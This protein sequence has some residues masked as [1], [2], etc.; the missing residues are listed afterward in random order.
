V[1][2]GHD[3]DSQRFEP[4]GGITELVAGAGGHGRYPVH[5][6]YPRLAF[7]DAAHYAALRLRLQ[8]GLARFAFVT[9]AGRTLDS[10]RLRC[11]S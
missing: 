2:G 4:V 1:L 7:G 6:S 3:H 5:R 9:G 11:R 10:G 8:P